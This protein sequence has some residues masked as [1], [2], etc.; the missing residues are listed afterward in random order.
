MQADVAG[1]ILMMRAPAGRGLVAI[2][3]AAGQLVLADPRTGTLR[4]IM[5]AVSPHVLACDF[6]RLFRKEDN[7]MLLGC[8]VRRKLSCHKQQP[9]HS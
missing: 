2:G 8:S 6:S 4:W 9:H 1:G 5:L 3:N 7:M